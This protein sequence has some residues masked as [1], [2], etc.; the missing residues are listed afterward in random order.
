MSE[1][2]GIDDCWNR[3]GV[4][5]REGE[6][7]PRLADA[8]HCRNC[9][10]YA[11]AGRAILCREIAL[12]SREEWTRIY[13]EAKAGEPADRVSSVVFRLGDEWLAIASAAVREITAACTIRRI[14]HF[15]SG[16]VK[17]L[18]N[19][20]GEL[21]LCISLG[22]L[23]ELDRG[24]RPPEFGSVGIA[25]R[26]LLLEHEGRRYLSPVTE[27]HGLL[28]YSAGEIQPP[29]ATLSRAK[30]TYTRGVL[31]WKDRHIAC[32]DEELLFYRMA[33]ELQ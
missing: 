9:P 32:L 16:L 14:P 4:W 5:R 27:V 20:R 21:H 18:A 2:I 29:P 31:H 12:E 11:E 10:V 3:I 22:S 28:R 6:P 25:N 33:K 30:A 23:L 13:A 19:I 26:M 24:E 1:R 8:V 15:G 7:C 17:G